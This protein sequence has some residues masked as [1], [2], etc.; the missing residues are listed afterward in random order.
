MSMETLLKLTNTSNKACI[1][2][3]QV[4]GLSEDS[5]FFFFLK[6]L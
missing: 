6:Y 2:Q 3:K 4:N 5:P 1:E